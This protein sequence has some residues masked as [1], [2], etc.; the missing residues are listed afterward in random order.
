MQ[1][2]KRKDYSYTLHLVQV[3]NLTYEYKPLQELLLMDVLVSNTTQNQVHKKENVQNE[4]NTIFLMTEN[5]D[6]F[7][8][9]FLENNSK[10]V[11]KFI[12]NMYF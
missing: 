11:K 4:E 2:G 6:S 3:I 7:S 5:T 10:E 9:V 1:Y 8:S 12:L